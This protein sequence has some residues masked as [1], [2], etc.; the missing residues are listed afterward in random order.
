M[1]GYSG[2]AGGSVFDQHDPSRTNW[3]KEFKCLVGS[4]VY[5][6]LILGT[7]IQN[8]TN[9]GGQ[10]CW[11]VQQGER[12]A[13]S[14]VFIQNIHQEKKEQDN[15]LH[16]SRCQLAS[17]GWGE[18]SGR[19]K[20]VQTRQRVSSG[21]GNRCHHNKPTAS[22]YWTYVRHKKSCLSLDQMQRSTCRFAGHIQNTRV[23]I[24]TIM[25][26]RTRTLF[27]FLKCCTA[28]PGTALVFFHLK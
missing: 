19:R 22:N 4:S 1:Q 12:R 27:L 5:Q 23:V 13:S 6:D 21:T 25:P 18:S 17:P 7:S 2:L 8:T 28:T 24:C 10:F 14:C 20:T 26:S 11:S 3:R 15:Y 16:G 9:I